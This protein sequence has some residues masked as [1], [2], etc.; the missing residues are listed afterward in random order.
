METKLN[1]P[2]AEFDVNEAT[3]DSSIGRLLVDLGKVSKADIERII[4][5]QNEK[6]MRF[7]D[8]ALNL[9]LIT[10][11]DIDQV[12]SMQFNYP[13]LQAG[14]GKYSAEL[15][16]GYAPFTP[17]VESLRTLR[18]QIMKLWFSEG[19]KT[20]AVVSVN[21]GEGASNLTAN[22]AILLSQLGQRTLLVDANLRSP[23]QHKLFQLAEKRG[24]SDIVA[25]RNDLN[26]ISNVEAFPNL[27]ILGA[28]TLPPNP[29]E[30]LN[31]ATFVEFMNQALSKYDL[32]LFDTS[33]AAVS[34]DSQ[35]I[36]A[37]CGGA[38]LVSKLNQTR[39]SDLAEVKAQISVTGARIVGAVINDF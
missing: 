30:L 23:Q 18:S 21:E 39:L 24:L 19:N 8:A 15:V 26:L 2:E 12:L 16:A 10:Q 22:L 32:I 31:R 29:Q 14:K 20:L 25:G 11:S 17:Q 35:A 38:L 5:V 27:S 7:G 34:A 13:Y 9:G 36:V 4:K 6:G 37:I 1:A 3:K 33:P 28:G